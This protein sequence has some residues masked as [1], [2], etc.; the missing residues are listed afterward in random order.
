MNLYER[1]TEGVLCTAVGRSS[2]FNGVS[3]PRGI[4]IA[5]AETDFLSNLRVFT[6][7]E[8]SYFFLVSPL[9]QKC[10]QYCRERFQSAFTPFFFFGRGI[11]IIEESREKQTI[12]RKYRCYVSR[13]IYIPCMITSIG[14]Y[15]ESDFSWL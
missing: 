7:R 8:V 13:E 15:L 9:R 1:Q 5:A 3:E 6:S 11:F 12:K 2:I 14:R 10:A 4:Y